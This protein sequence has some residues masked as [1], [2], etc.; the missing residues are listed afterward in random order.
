MICES[1]STVIIHRVGEPIMHRPA[2]EEERAIVP[3]PVVLSD[4]V[5]AALQESVQQGWTDLAVWYRDGCPGLPEEMAGIVPR[6]AAVLASRG[7]LPAADG[8]PK[9]EQ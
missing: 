3:P 9:T 4:E 8:E 5:R 7:L 1:C 2:T 6:L